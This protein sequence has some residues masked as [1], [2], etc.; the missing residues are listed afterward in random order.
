MMVRAIL[1]AP[2]VKR[3]W[4]S[5]DGTAADGNILKETAA[6]GRG[7]TGERGSTST[8]YITQATRCPKDDAD[9][10]ADVG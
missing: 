9:S 1:I 3:M 10:R 7:G 5:N 2:S 6:T 4:P 8:Q